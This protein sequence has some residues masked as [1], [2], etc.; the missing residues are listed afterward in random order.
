[1]MND[2]SALQKLKLIEE[3]DLIKMKRKETRTIRIEDES[4]S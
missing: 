4:F 1:M 3:G 2:H